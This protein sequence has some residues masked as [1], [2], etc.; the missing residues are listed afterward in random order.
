ME[1]AGREIPQAT[2]DKIRRLESQIEEIEQDIA[3][4]RQDIVELKQ[5]YREDIERLEVITGEE[6]TLPLE[7]AEGR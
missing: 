6:R 4:Q 2:L 1:R 3:S 7:V 5:N